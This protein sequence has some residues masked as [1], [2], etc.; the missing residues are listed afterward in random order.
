MNLSE[1]KRK[2]Y[3]DIS[4]TIQR[5]S[6]YYIDCISGQVLV[7]FR[8]WRKRN[9]YLRRDHDE[10]GSGNDTDVKAEQ[11][12]DSLKRY[13]HRKPRLCVMQRD[14]DPSPGKSRRSVYEVILEAG[15]TVSLAD[16]KSDRMSKSESR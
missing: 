1:G 10:R 7:N 4:G 14:P 8:R 9:C 5:F 6:G 16:G 13:R 11:S 2:K 3:P 15:E 12:L